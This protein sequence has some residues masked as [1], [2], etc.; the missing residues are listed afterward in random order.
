MKTMKMNKYFA[1]AALEAAL[2]RTDVVVQPRQ[3]NTWGIQHIHIMPHMD[4]V[5]IILSAVV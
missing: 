3:S 1:M 2:T 5:I 4:P